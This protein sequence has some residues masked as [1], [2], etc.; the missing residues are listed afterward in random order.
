MFI[1]VAVKR[2]ALALVLASAVAGAAEA[3]TAMV[4]PDARR[5]YKCST[6][7]FT[8]PE[9]HTA[10]FSVTLDEYGP[11]QGVYAVMR[12]LNPLGILMKHRT[13]TI[14]PGASVTLDHSVAGQ[15]RLQAELFVPASPTGTLTVRGESSAQ[16]SL[17]LNGTDIARFIGPPIWTLALVPCVNVAP[18]L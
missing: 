7:L 14:R 18:V 12:F 6:S 8:I 2:S 4:P 17:S 10:S 15:Y 9:G 11:E 5:S 3:Q 1:P 16:A 13:T